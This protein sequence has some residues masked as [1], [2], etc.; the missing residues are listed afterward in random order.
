MRLPWAYDGVHPA[1]KRKPAK[2]TNVEDFWLGL[3]AYEFRQ[4]GIKFDKSADGQA[5]LEFFRANGFRDDADLIRPA[6]AAVK[7]RLREIDDL[8][9]KLF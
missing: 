2:W 1:I 9:A 7:E 8:Y 4:A 6:L 5:A 3:T